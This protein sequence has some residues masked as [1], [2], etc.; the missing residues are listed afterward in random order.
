MEFVTN[1]ELRKTLGQHLSQVRFAGKRFLIYRHG[2]EFAA[3]VSVRDLDRLEEF[4]RKSVR[5]KELE[6]QI[7]ADAWERAKKGE[8]GMVI[9]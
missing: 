9:R 5:Q 2:R 3:L 8:P 6:Y 1:T 7:R 4:D